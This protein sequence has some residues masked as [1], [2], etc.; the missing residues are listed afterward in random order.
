MPSLLTQHRDY[1]IKRDGGFRCYYCH[2]PLR[3]NGGRYDHVHRS[4]TG[5]GSA[6]VDH[7]V[8]ICNGGPDH[9]DNLVLACALCNH[10]KDKGCHIEFFRLKQY[11]RAKRASRSGTVQDRITLP[12]RQSRLNA[13]R[14]Q[15]RIEALVAPG[16]RRRWSVDRVCRWK[17]MPVRV[18]DIGDDGNDW[19][20]R[21][22]LVGNGRQ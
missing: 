16:G 18:V 13:L 4:E 22:A 1:L 14:S 9:V 2:I 12:K 8:A 7:L 17:D 6:T 21:I 20:I 5:H 15:G 10:D 3:D 11:A 19:V